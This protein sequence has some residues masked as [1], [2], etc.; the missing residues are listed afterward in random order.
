MAISSSN[1]IS[2]VTP[3]Q[4]P[5]LHLSSPA[6]PSHRSESP[7]LALEETLKDYLRTGTLTPGRREQILS[8]AG[9]NTERITELLD[10]HDTVLIKFHSQ[11]SLENLM[12]LLSEHLTPFTRLQRE[13]LFECVRD[14]VDCNFTEEN[15]SHAASIFQTYCLHR[16]NT[17]SFQKKCSKAFFDWN[18]ELLP[19]PQP[20]QYFRP[21]H[22]QKHDTSLDTTY[23]EYVAVPGID[24]RYIAAE[25]ARLLYEMS[26]DKRIDTIRDRVQR[27]QEFRQLK[28]SLQASSSHP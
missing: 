24:R 16:E 20:D 23:H 6:S 5:V 11:K 14:F 2:P 4:S 8:Q 28:K 27:A 15:E 12:D 1:P 19:L 21:Q 10:L 25:H 17:E 7:S 26:R 18:R 9:K 13:F 3:R 22:S